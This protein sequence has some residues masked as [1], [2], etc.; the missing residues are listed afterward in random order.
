MNDLLSQL[1]DFESQERTLGNH[2]G[3]DI[4]LDTRVALEQAQVEN[5]AA[6]LTK[7]IEAF[8]AVSDSLT[9]REIVETS[10]FPAA[11]KSIERLSSE[12]ERR[13]EVLRNLVNKLDECQ[14]HID[15]AFQMAF[16]VRGHEYKGPNYGE[17]MKAARALVSEERERIKLISCTHEWKMKRNNVE[18]CDIC[19]AVRA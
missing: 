6:D 18:E 13:L 19:G 5:Q 3:A 2:E 10:D 15:G 7:A 4:L 14:S 16:S 9:L 17:E 12:G 8:A 11:I 1:S